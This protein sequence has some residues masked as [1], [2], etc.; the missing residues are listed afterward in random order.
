MTPRIAGSRSAFGQQEPDAHPLDGV[1]VRKGVDTVN[2]RAVGALHRNVPVA[3]PL[4]IEQ[5]SEGDTVA[6]F[7]DSSGAASVIAVL[8]HGNARASD[9]R[10]DTTPPQA[11]IMLRVVQ[12]AFSGPFLE[13][14]IRPSE[15]PI[16]YYEV[17]ARQ[18]GGAWGYGKYPFYEGTN[19]RHFPRYSVALQCRVRSVDLRGNTSAWSVCEDLLVDTLAPPVPQGLG[20]TSIVDAVQLTWSGPTLQEVKDLSGFE[21]YKATQASGSDAELVRRVGATLSTTVPCMAGVVY[22]FNLKAL[23]LAGNISDFG[24]VWVEGWATQPGQMQLLVNS[25]FSRDR[26]GDGEPDQWSIDAA[27]GDVTWAHGDYGIHGGK[28][29]RV[30]VPDIDDVHVVMIEQMYYSSGTAP[31]ILAEVGK[32]YVC[33][34]YVKSDLNE[35]Y[36]DLDKQA[37]AAGRVWLCCMLAV[38]NGLS[39]NYLVADADGTTVE[40]LAD[41]WHRIMYSR[42]LV[43]SDLE[44][45]TP[46]AEYVG[47]LVAIWIQTPPS[48]FTVDIDRVQMETETVTPWGPSIAPPGG[49]DG[50]SSYG[51]LMDTSGI[52]T[53]DGKFF[54]SSDGALYSPLL[55]RERTAAPDLP[56]ADS[57]AQIFLWHSPT[58]HYLYLVIAYLDGATERYNYLRLDTA[59]PSW[60]YGTSL[61]DP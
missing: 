43:Q 39:A 50:A 15:Q 19:M 29:I 2:V 51:L 11:P 47:F 31:I 56:A 57:E 60:G 9:A 8:G 44:L 22:Y 36:W 35:F 28:G 24:P 3:P 12:D 33:T 37:P 42:V 48:A 21:V 23:D 46:E 20:A 26:D 40:T 1:V 55:F 49:V 18:P 10:W 41:G 53:E 61:P 27:S 6:L 32:K 14:N 5:V 4:T 34:M 54:L 58:K 13:W 59:S 30:S 38:G 25:D 17:D 16:A 45:L 7:W 52:K